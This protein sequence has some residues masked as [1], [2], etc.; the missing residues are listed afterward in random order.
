MTHR[1]PSY[2]VNRLRLLV[3]TRSR[4]HEPWWT[5]GAV[6][7][8]DRWLTRDDVVVEFGSGRSTKWLAERAA[9]V[10]SIEHHSRMQRDCV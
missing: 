3:R 10:V 5:G 6:A 4:P 2:V 1:T 7:L 9:R 8:A